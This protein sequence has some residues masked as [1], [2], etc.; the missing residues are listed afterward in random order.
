MFQ[1]CQNNH[2][3]EGKL[4]RFDKVKMLESR[5]ITEDGDADPRSASAALVSA[6]DAIPTRP[7]IKE[8]PYKP[9]IF[10]AMPGTLSPAAI[11]FSATLHVIFKLFSKFFV[12]RFSKQARRWAGPCL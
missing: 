10:Y 11:S 7:F 8:A 9:F 5:V 12:L 2:G 3:T 4:F 1:C 6:P